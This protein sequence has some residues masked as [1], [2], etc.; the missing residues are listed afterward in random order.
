M[1]GGKL[2]ILGGGG[3]ARVVIDALLARGATI[4]G[5][6]DPALAAGGKGA[7]DIRVLGGDEAL[8]GR[9]P[10]SVLLANGIGS[11]QSTE[12]R[13]ARFEYFIGLGFAFVQ[14]IH[15]SATL[16]RDACL[17]EGAQ[18]MA[19]AVLQSGTALGRNV[20]V[21]TR[22]SLDHEC[23]IADHVHIAPGATLSGG[24]AVGEGS[25]VGT[26]AI[27]I[28]GVRIGRNCLIGAGAVVLKDVP[29][30][31]TLVTPQSRVTAGPAS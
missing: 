27:V 12:R 9:D 30:G 18:V 22:A 16:A 31:A 21:N 14:V 2:I 3:H 8:I 28:Q 13:R 6:V 26:G 23:R 1:S 29:D 20:L 19:G 7:F 11:T 4:E 25:H 17:A 10:A 15:P 5:L 24:V